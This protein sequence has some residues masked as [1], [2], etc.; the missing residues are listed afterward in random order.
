MF[1]RTKLQRAAL[2]SSI[3]IAGAS[4]GGVEC[5]PVEESAAANLYA[6]GRDAFLDELR[7][8]LLGDADVVGR[9]L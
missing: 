4:H 1:K 6:G 8:W 3:S 7:E 2:P 5:V 9:L